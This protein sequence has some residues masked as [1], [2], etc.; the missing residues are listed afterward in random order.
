MI[1]KKG[2][3]MDILNLHELKAV[4]IQ[5]NDTD[6]LITATEQPSVIACTHCGT[7]ED[8]QRFGK[9]EHLFMDTPI[10]AKR[11]GILLKRQRYRCKACNGTFFANI[12]DLDSKR[13]C[14]RRLIE[15]IEKKALR[16]TFVSIADTVGVDEKTVRNIFRDYIEKLAETVE[17]EIP[18]IMGIDEIHIISKP[19]CVIT[20]IEHNT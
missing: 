5:E 16:Q 14:T 3:N 20:N 11:V 18:R 19:R 1:E 15:Y 10:H 9:K 17:F 8:Y 13:N 4:N 2:T 7:I 12:E 6:Y